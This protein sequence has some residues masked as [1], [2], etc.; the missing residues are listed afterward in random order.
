MI[1]PETKN[2]DG[3]GGGGQGSSDG[4]IDGAGTGAAADR[5][6]VVAAVGNGGWVGGDGRSS[7]KQRWM[8]SSSE[9]QRAASPLRLRPSS[10]WWRPWTTSS[11][12]RRWVASPS[13][14]LLRA[15]RTGDDGW[16]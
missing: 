9:R 4:H 12:E 8:T 7:P 2:E 10:E 15:A 1:S 3:E 5:R 16:C 14:I 11:N 6:P 13:W